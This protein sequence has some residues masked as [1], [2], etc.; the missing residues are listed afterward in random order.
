MCLFINKEDVT[1]YTANQDIRVYK[2]FRIASVIG[3]E[4]KYPLLLE[5]P[6]QGTKHY[7]NSTMQPKDKK[8]RYERIRKHTT[9]MYI[10]PERLIEAYQIGID[11]VHCFVAQ[12][13]A[14]QLLAKSF[15]YHPHA[16]YGL[17]ECKIPA[18]TRYWVS[19]DNKEIGAR[20]LYINSF[21]YCTTMEGKVISLD[22]ALKTKTID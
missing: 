8:I 4:R 2:V 3:D 5:T 19:Y 7:I 11:A 14:K 9:E 13:D 22:E 10:T 18:G 12:E 17:F 15:S 20:S 1:P 21:R 16:V 6:Y